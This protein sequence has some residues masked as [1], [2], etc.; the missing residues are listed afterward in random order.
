MYSM[1]SYY[2]WSCHIDSY[3]W[4][5]RVFSIHPNISIGRDMST[6]PVH[7]ELLDLARRRDH[8]LVTVI[9]SVQRLVREKQPGQQGMILC[10]F[11]AEVGGW[12]CRQVK[13]DCVI[14]IM[15][16]LHLT[17]ICSISLLITHSLQVSNQCDQ[18]ICHFDKCCSQQLDCLYPSDEIS[19][20]LL[21]WSLELA[22]PFLKCSITSSPS[23]SVSSF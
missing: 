6:A 19:S 2:S 10:K 8:G 16:F 22:M 7:G 14:N 15:H 21:E 5:F 20:I 4:C 1:Y 12:N 11:Q 13:Y 9:T 3:C 18:N 17:S 23:A